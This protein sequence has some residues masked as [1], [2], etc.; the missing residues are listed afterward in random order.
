MYDR[1]IRLWGLEAQNRMKQSKILVIRLTAIANEVIKNIV[2]A[3]V[4]S[5]TILDDRV[6]DAVDLGAEFFLEESDIGKYRAQAAF[7]RIQKLNPR[8]KLS[9]ETKNVFSIEDYW[10]SKFDVVVATELD[11][12]ELVKVNKSVREAGNKFYCSGLFG[13]SGYVFVDLVS[14]TFKIEREMSNIVTP[15]GPE[16]ST[17]HIDKV[18]TKKDGDKFIETITK[19]E[20]YSSLLEIVEKLKKDDNEFSV[21]YKPKRL[22]K[23]SPLLPTLLSF[24]DCS[25]CEHL[26]LKSVQEKARHLGLPAGIVTESYV[27]SFHSGV[28][29]APVA[30][31]IGG[32]L[33]QDLLN[34]L[35]GKEQ[36]IQN[37]FLFDALTGDGPIYCL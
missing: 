21:H 13:M 27:N 18:E 35:G 10:L 37:L 24:W 22:L 3:G 29:L 32:V 20:K 31:V 17:R 33:A 12:Q 2:L 19:T 36:P 4:G 30:A 23:I 16:T 15:V 7:K 5:L 28:E 14:H 25:H 26:T 9:I 34:I 1:Q 11:Y 6:V 8:V